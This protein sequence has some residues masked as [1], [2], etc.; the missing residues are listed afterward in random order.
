M[1]RYIKSNMLGPAFNI[2][3]GNGCAYTVAGCIYNY[4]DEIYDV[5][6]RLITCVPS[7]EFAAVKVKDYLDTGLVDAVIVNGTIEFNAS[8]YWNKTEIISKILEEE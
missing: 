8:D 4:E 5:V 7:I 2:N 6:D 1:K 3:E